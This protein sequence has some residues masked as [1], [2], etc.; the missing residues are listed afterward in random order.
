MSN[1]DFEGYSDA[2]ELTLAIARLR[3]RERISFE[4]GDI[5]AANDAKVALGRA[6]ARLVQLYRERGLLDGA[7]P[8]GATATPAER[9]AKGWKNVLANPLPEV[10]P[11]P[12]K[13][14]RGRKPRLKS[15]EAVP[16]P[17]PDHLERTLTYSTKLLAGVIRAQKFTK[18]H[19]KDL[20]RLPISALVFLPK[21]AQPLCTAADLEALGW[22]RHLI[23]ELGPLPRGRKYRRA[24]ILQ[25]VSGARF[26]RELVRLYQIRLEQARREPGRHER[27]MERFVNGRGE[28]EA[29]RRRKEDNARYQEILQ[30]RR[31]LEAGDQGVTPISKKPDLTVTPMRS[32]PAQ[33]S[34]VSGRT[35]KAVK[36]VCPVCKKGDLPRGWLRHQRCEA[37]SRSHENETTDPALSEAALVSEPRGSGEYRR[38][39]ALVERK[40]E[41]ARGKRAAGA[42][43]PVR[44]PEARKA[45]LERCE[46][47][48]ENPACTGQPDD[49]TDAGQ[50][51]LEV[52]HIDEIAGG[53][54]DHP[55]VMVA[56]C[57][58]CH[59]V[60]TR[61]R[62]RKQLTKILR[63]VAE[64]AH[65]AANT[66]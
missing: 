16:A 26:Q 8:A 31:T 1:Q 11:K 29:A 56:L 64:R 46:G 10:A 9:A 13:R 42:A 50:A 57:P 38:L 15:G 45:V 23:T 66:L 60:K 32:I 65:A 28:S 21:A 22:S 34:S 48:C 33:A 36:G 7:V 40:E 39:V 49:V 51:L 47:R 3:T 24:H 17:Q 20:A 62:T 58:N 59:A 41:A 19:E 55:R 61:G 53:G 43:R 54:R 27:D 12:R 52:D 4:G 44:I 18:R 14:D 5:Q 6:Q 25:R 2:N 30:T 37:R 63:G 35:G